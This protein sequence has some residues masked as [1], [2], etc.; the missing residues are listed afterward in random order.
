MVLENALILNGA[1][2]CMR[3]NV[4]VTRQGNNV[5]TNKSMSS[6][7]TISSATPPLQMNKKIH[8]SDLKQ[9]YE[10]LHAI[11]VGL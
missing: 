9:V 5:V 11:I 7:Q 2:N 8:Q 1:P 10:L 4:D 6:G 3:P